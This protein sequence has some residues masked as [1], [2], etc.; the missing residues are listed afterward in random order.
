MKKQQWKVGLRALGGREADAGSGAKAPA[1]QVVSRR[2]AAADA[3]AAGLQFLE[4]LQTQDPRATNG[5]NLERTRRTVESGEPAWG[6]APPNLVAGATA[7]LSGDVGKS[8][9]DGNA[10]AEASSPG[11]AGGELAQAVLELLVF[12]D[13]DGAA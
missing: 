3:T 6:E 9:L 10:L 1:K 7:L 8:V 12:G 5:L 13:V 4:V 11:G 2:E